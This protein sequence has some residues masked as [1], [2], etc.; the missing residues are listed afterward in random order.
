M[1]RFRLYSNNGGEHLTVEEED[2]VMG[3]GKQ[4]K[5]NTMS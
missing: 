5:P 2:D 1:A 3:N 4:A